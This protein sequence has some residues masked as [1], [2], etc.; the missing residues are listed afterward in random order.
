VNISDYSSTSGTVANPV[1]VPASFDPFSPSPKTVLTRKAS[2]SDGGTQISPLSPEN[3][4]FTPERNVK[5]PVPMKFPSISSAYSEPF[6]PVSSVSKHS[7]PHNRDKSPEYCDPVS[8]PMGLY[9]GN[10]GMPMNGVRRGAYEEVN[11][12]TKK[13]SDRNVVP[14]ERKPSIK[15]KVPAKKTSAEIKDDE[16]A[17][18]DRYSTEKWSLQPVARGKHIEHEGNYS[19]AELDKYKQVEHKAVDK[20]LGNHVTKGTPSGPGGKWISDPTYCEVEIGGVYFRFK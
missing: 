19:Y 8:K 7:Y 3:L 10:A 16:Y 6:S 18:A 14:V 15:S 2:G 1:K 4:G 17:Y 20:K 9:S 5:P 11:Y 13:P 12:D